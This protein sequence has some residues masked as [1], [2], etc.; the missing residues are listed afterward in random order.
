[1]SPAA[2][3]RFVDTGNPV[4]AIECP[5]C[6][7]MAPRFLQYCKNCGFALW[8]SGPYASA[9]FIAWRDADPQT[10]GRAR[11]YDLEIPP[12]LEEE[13]ERVIDYDARAHELGIHM[14][15]SSPYPIV[16]CLGFLF[17]AFAAIPFPIPMRIGAGVIGAI[18]FL[19]GIFGWVLHEDGRNYQNMVQSEHGAG[20]GHAP[21]ST[22][23]EHEE[24][25]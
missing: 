3:P 25:E 7:L 12:P 14:T 4:L 13:E 21:D 8:P 17:L 9:A 19:S 16:I 18:F 15:P 20:H 10:R 22:T 24:H 5:N 6:G 2:K 1:V 11:R 23:H